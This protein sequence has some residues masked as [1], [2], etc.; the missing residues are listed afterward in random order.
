[1]IKRYKE[2][3]FGILLGAGFW[4]VD[5]AMHAEIG[6]GVD[7]HGFWTEIFAPHPTALLFRLIYFVLAIA[8]GV[9]LWRANWRERELRAFEKAVLTF[10]RHLD[11][12]SLRI[13]SLVKRL[14]NRNSVQLDHVAA[15]LIEEIIV[16]A[17]LLNELSQK[18]AHFSEQ[19][20]AG[21]TTEA[22]ETLR[23]IE[24]RLDS[25]NFRQNRE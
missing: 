13:L 3:F 4:L 24:T 23:A 6:A 15:E 16:D 19:V 25:N 12:P 8:F 10:Q 7:S 18:Y 17:Q 5:A 11:R 2:I 9:S 20:R 21:R 14:Q 1:M 22:T